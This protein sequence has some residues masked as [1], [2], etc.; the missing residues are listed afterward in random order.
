VIARYLHA[1]ASRVNE[2]ASRLLIPM[3]YWW[4]NTLIRGR[5]L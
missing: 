2:Y 1:R 5:Q 4:K 3:R